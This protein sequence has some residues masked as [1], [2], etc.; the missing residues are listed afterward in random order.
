MNL[1]NQESYL[2]KSY[3]M[4]HWFPHLWECQGTTLDMEMLALE[5]PRGSWKKF[6][7]PVDSLLTGTYSPHSAHWS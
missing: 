2:A 6:W 3:H 4:G 5:A 7:Q 1:K